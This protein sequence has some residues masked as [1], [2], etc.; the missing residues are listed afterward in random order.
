MLWAFIN[1]VPDTKLL[2]S[3]PIVTQMFFRNPTRCCLMNAQEDKIT[4]IKDMPLGPL[5]LPR[6]HTSPPQWDEIEV[7]P[8]PQSKVCFLTLLFLSQNCPLPRMTDGQKTH[9]PPRKSHW[10]PPTW[11]E[12]KFGPVALITITSINISKIRFIP[13]RITSCAGHQQYS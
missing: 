3:T 10:R 9:S 11:H 7:S 1:I 5:A 12:V 13:P 2:F 8:S 6:I 4:S